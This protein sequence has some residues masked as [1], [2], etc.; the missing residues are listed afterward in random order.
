MILAKA[1]SAFADTPASCVVVVLAAELQPEVARAIA[2]ATANRV[3]LLIMVFSSP[4]L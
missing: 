4:D 2:A 3:V 1:S